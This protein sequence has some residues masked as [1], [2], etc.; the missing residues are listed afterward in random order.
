MPTFIDVAHSQQPH[1]FPSRAFSFYLSRSAGAYGSRLLIG[2]NIDHTRFIAPGDALRYVPV[3]QPVYWMVA[4]ESMGVT[5]L[6][7]TTATSSIASNSTSDHRNESAAAAHALPAYSL[8]VDICNRG[9]APDSPNRTDS[10]AYAADKDN[11][12]AAFIDSGTS[13]IGIPSAVLP[14]LLVAVTR[15]Y[16]CWPLQSHANKYLA[17]DCTEHGLDQ[18]PSLHVAMRATRDSS[19]T[20]RS[21]VNIEI[22]PVDYVQVQESTIS[23]VCIPSLLA[24]G[25]EKYSDHDNV[26]ILGTP[27]L[28]SH[29]VTFEADASGGA[30]I[31][32]ARS[33]AAP[34]PS[35]HGRTKWQRTVL[36]STIVAVVLGAVAQVASASQCR[37]R[38]R[39]AECQAG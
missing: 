4:L 9:I 10:K 7:S 21:I 5:S 26:I 34:P 3:T 23:S 38:M 18:F 16:E 39:A 37:R 35:Q 19:D 24:L 25:D 14:Q 22:H 15:G 8:V 13:F 6:D 12:C 27:F 20:Q 17:C 33:A 29:Y 32:V 31:G 36:T 30:R 1:V 28:R 11:R 2:S